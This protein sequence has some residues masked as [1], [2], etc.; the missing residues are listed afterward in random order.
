MEVF[1]PC[2]HSRMVCS[3]KSEN[4]MDENTGYL[5]FRTPSNIIGYSSMLWENSGSEPDN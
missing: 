4:E 1:I 3:R 2:W 5:H